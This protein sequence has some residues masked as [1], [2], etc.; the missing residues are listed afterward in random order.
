MYKRPKHL[1]LHLNNLH[2]LQYDPLTVRQFGVVNKPTSPEQKKKGGKKKWKINHSADISQDYSSEEEE[3]SLDE[4]AIGDEEKKP[5]E[6]Q[7][8]TINIF[9]SGAP[10][11]ICLSVSK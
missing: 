9:R 5:K 11:W 4:D 3:R 6:V 1:S 7:Y 10:L 2:N 8:S